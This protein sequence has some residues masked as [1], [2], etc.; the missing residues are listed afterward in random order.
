MS[1]PLRLLHIASFSGNVGDNANH[2]G[3][4]P[5]FEAQLGAPAAWTNLEIREFYW[6]ERQWDAG[7]VEFINSHD[8][9]IIGGGNY[10]ELWVEHSP[11]GTSIAMDPKLFD[12]IKVPVFFNALGVDPGQGVP[13]ISRER[14]TTFLDKLLSSEQ[15]LVSV[16]NDG[17]RE[18]LRQHIG[19]AYSD[20]VHD[21]PDHGFFVPSPEETSPWVQGHTGQRVAIN[22][23]CDMSETRFA[24]FESQTAFAREM[25]SVV[26]NLAE[27]DRQLQ[28]CLVPHIFRDLEIIS[29]TIGFLDDRLRRTRLTVAPFGSGDAAARQTLSVYRSADLVMGMRFH[30]NVCPM[31]LG[32]N[33]LALNCYPQIENLY[34]GLDL[35]ERLLNVGQAGFGGEATRRAEQTLAGAD[36][37]SSAIGPAIS[38][39]S[40]LRS[41]FEPHL[42]RWLPQ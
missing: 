37:F 21:L 36:G 9:L 29:Q 13:D 26:T 19:Q 38:R 4:R 33:V 24:G 25:A 23:A 8:M 41:N 1:T 7:L 12:D 14:F 5:W 39:V 15:Y 30:A 16:R 34:R 11:T 28:F 27:H 2:M 22:L 42:Q 3:F 10:F 17:A 31:A 32:S 20:Q 6:R 18:N 35:A 40:Q